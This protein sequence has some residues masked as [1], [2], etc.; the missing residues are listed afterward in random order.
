MTMVE[1]TPPQTM[2]S[3]G[4]FNVGPKPTGSVEFSV[5]IMKD[6]ENQDRL[7]KEEVAISKGA[8]MWAALKEQHKAVWMWAEQGNINGFLP[9]NLSDKEWNGI[10][11]GAD[12]AKLA[13]FNKT[14]GTSLAEAIKSRYGLNNAKTWLEAAVLFSHGAELK[15]LRPNNNK[16]DESSNPMYGVGVFIPSFSD[17]KQPCLVAAVVKCFTV[18]KREQPRMVS[19][20][21]LLPATSALEAVGKEVQKEPFGD[22]KTPT[23]LCLEKSTATSCD[24][25]YV[26][27]RRHIFGK[28]LPSD[29]YAEVTRVVIG[30]DCL[31]YNI[32]FTTS[33][34]V[35]DIMQNGHTRPFISTDSWGA[36]MR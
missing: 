3:K 23:R 6:N 11:C 16:M 15:G 21:V 33:E 12:K 5:V 25:F 32:D 8:E 9:Q 26:A 17:D 29:S 4:R 2:P 14:V 20:A 36:S 22:L 13:H 19:T 31:S 10:I 7:I 1:K 35:G 24:M 28:D 27:D 34:L 30:A 18:G